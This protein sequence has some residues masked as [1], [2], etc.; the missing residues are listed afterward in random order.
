MIG[1]WQKYPRN[2]C[3]LNSPSQNK[4]KIPPWYVYC[5][6][7]IHFLINIIIIITII[8]ITITIIIIIFTII[9]NI[10]IIIIVI[11]IIIIIIINITSPLLSSLLTLP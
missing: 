6:W 11:A 1:K 3:E 2:I 7:R 4:I 5:D 10:I 8:I 9:N